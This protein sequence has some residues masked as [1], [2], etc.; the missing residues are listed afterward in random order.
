[1]NA[2]TWN[3]ESRLY[4]YISKGLRDEKTLGILKPE[5]VLE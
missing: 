2:G 5:S 1:M 4:Y 3:I